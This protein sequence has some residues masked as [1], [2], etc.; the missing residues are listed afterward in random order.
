MVRL[1]GADRYATNNTVNLTAVHRW[2]A[3]RSSQRAPTS[4]THWLLDRC[5]DQN[6]PLVLT[7]AEQ[8]QRVRVEHARQPRDHARDHRGWNVSSVGERRKT[9]LKAAGITIDYRIAGTDRTATAA[10]DRDVGDC[11][12]SCVRCVRGS[13][14]VAFAGWPAANIAQ[15]YV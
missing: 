14:L 6:Y 11:R 2:A 7:D 1:A 3:G 13:S 9:Q 4:Q 12:S 5:H 8:P 15:V 10:I